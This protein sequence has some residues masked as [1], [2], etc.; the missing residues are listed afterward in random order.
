MSSPFLFSLL[1]FITSTTLFSAAS[2]T[3]SLRS[4]YPG[5]VPRQ[6]AHTAL[7][8]SAVRA[9][10]ASSYVSRFSSPRAPQ[11]IRSSRLSAAFQDC[12]MMMNDSAS[13]L[14]QSVEELSRLGRAGTPAFRL[15]MSNINTRVSAALTDQSMCLSSLSQAGAAGGKA[16]AAITKKVKEVSL[17]TGNAL[18]LVNKINS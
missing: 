11:S 18:S 3:D 17:V 12:I 14:K 1:L 15:S 4:S 8:I 10:E 2:P 7:N 6:L 16:A 9:R 5:S 13:R